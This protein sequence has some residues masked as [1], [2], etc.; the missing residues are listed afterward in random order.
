RPAQTLLGKDSLTGSDRASV[1]MQP[2]TSATDGPIVRVR[3][4]RF[5]HCAPCSL[6]IAIARDSGPSVGRILCPTGLDEERR[7]GPQDRRS[8]DRVP[9]RERGRF[10]EPSFGSGLAQ[11]ALED[12]PRR[13]LRQ[14]CDELHPFGHLE[15]GQPG[16]DVRD[17]L[18]TGELA[19]VGL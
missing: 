9:P 18:V 19:L 17:H 1:A 3:P 14:L 11:T 15:T 6:F 8:R 10:L 5:H 16:P 12:L 2:P 7:G 4:F 13:V